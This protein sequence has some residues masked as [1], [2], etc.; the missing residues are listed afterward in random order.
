MLAIHSII[1]NLDYHL[2]VHFL[3]IGHFQIDFAQKFGKIRLIEKAVEGVTIFIEKCFPRRIHSALQF[4]LNLPKNNNGDVLR[5]L[6]QIQIFIL[7]TEIDQHTENFELNPCE[8]C[9]V[10]KKM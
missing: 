3:H 5:K 4:H 1:V 2:H 7:K 8:C 9:S 6:I 10:A